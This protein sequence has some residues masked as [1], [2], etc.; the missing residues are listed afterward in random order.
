[1]LEVGCGS[2]EFTVRLK[3][4]GLGVTAFDLTENCVR[5][6]AG[7]LKSEEEINCGV[8][9]ITAMPYSADAFDICFGVSILHHVPLEA[10]FHEI[11][12]VLR[13]GGRFFFSEPNMFNPQI[14]VEKNIGWIKRR[15]EDSPS[16]TA[17]FRRSL[18]RRL[19][20]VSGVQATVENIDF[21][22][23]LVPEKLL[24][25]VEKISDF[26]EKVPLVK[27]LSGS[28]AITGTVSK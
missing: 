15:L 11:V 23:P 2:G 7:Q 18:A 20:A 5:H 24:P 17:F 27:E 26:A 16:E 9:D 19:N 6:A 14:A 10:A 28:L 25:L 22:H 21:L 12:R 8:A 3:G 4:L 1:V 13:S